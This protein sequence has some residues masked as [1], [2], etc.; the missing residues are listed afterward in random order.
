M[1][2]AARIFQLEPDLP[3]PIPIEQLCQQLDITSI[4]NLETGGFEAALITDELKSS[5]AILVAADRPRQRQR[6]SIAHELAHFLIPTHLPT[7]GEQSLCSTEHF[8]LVDVQADDRRRRREAEANRLAALLLIPPHVLRPELQKIRSPDVGDLVRLARLFDVSKEAVSRAYT[9]YSREAV[10]VV[11]IQ[12][13]RVLRSYRNANIFP[14]IEVAAGQAVPKGSIY[15]DGPRF[16]GSISAVE[17]CELHLWLGDREARKVVSLT[18]Q[19]LEQRNG[20]ALLMLHA[21]MADDDDDD[22]HDRGR[23][24]WR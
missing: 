7:P 5:G 20:F 10:A 11:V 16:P 24:R 15:H 9:D 21:E 3:I 2:I 14:W 6:Y 19:V 1:A 18:E 23:Q 13:G 17:E 12:N 4:G 8:R 22:E